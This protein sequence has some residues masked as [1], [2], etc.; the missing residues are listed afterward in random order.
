MLNKNISDEI[1]FFNFLVFINNTIWKHVHSTLA[2]FNELTT[3]YCIYLMKKITIQ[4]FYIMGIN[5]E[6]IKD[7]TSFNVFIYLFNL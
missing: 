5:N 6:G 4:I 3:Q 2:K 1:L 7:M